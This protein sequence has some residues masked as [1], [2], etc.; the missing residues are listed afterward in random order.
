MTTYLT[1]LC[2][3]MYKLIVTMAVIQKIK[4]R[5]IFIKP[6]DFFNKKVYSETEVVRRVEPLFIWRYL[7]QENHLLTDRIPFI[8]VGF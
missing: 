2:Q 7:F 5:L 6:I 3:L 1:W 4:I 8:S